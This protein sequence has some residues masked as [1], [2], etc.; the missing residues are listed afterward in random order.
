[1]PCFSFLCTYSLDLEIFRS[2]FWILI[3]WVL[4]DLEKLFIDFF[5]FASLEL[6]QY[7]ELYY[8]ANPLMEKRENLIRFYFYSNIPDKDYEFLCFIARSFVERGLSYNC[9]ALFSH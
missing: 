8:V 2:F 5:L 9:S 3:Q 6:F 1:M 7:C 4:L